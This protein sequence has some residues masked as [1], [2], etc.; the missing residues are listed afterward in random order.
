MEGAYAAQDAI[1]E[2]W[3][4]CMELLVE[5]GKYDEFSVFQVSESDVTETCGELTID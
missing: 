4:N 2:Y 1:A 5:T 3:E